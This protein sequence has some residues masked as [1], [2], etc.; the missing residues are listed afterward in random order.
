MPTPAPLGYLGSPPKYAVSCTQSGHATC[1]RSA[2]VHS[3]APGCSSPN[4]YGSNAKNF[5]ISVVPMP[6]F[7]KDSFGGFAGFQWVTINPNPT[8]DSPNIWPQPGR[9]EP[10]ARGQV[11]RIA[12]GPFQ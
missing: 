7:A 9:E 3:P 11:N 12:E 4:S 1:R 5:Q 10:A 6:S 8:F 2:G